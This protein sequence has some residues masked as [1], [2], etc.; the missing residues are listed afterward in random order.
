MIRPE[1]RASVEEADAR[2]TAVNVAVEPQDQ[3]ARA[4]LFDKSSGSQRRSGRLLPAADG[5]WVFLGGATVNDDPRK[6]YSTLESPGAAARE[7]DSAGVLR[8]I[9]DH[10]FLMILDAKPESYEIYELRR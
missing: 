4:L 6:T 5:T 9:G 10:H 1:H 7:S 2:A 8:K 3:D